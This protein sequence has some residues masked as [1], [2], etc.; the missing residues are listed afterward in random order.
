M[1]LNYHL[2]LKYLKILSYL[3]L[4]YYLM[5]LLSQKYLKYLMFC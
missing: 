4:H 5:S 2:Y 3:T 1:N